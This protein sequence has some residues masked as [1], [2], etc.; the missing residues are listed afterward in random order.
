MSANQ[1]EDEQYLSEMCQ[2][3]RGFK[4]W[5]RNNVGRLAPPAARHRSGLYRKRVFENNET[6]SRTSRKDFKTDQ[7]K[8]TRRK[9]DKKGACGDNGESIKNIIYKLRDTHSLPD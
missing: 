5:R 9:E 6:S 3:G 7:K 4:G 2:T 8:A 1:D